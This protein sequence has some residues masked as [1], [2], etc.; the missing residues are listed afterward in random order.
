MDRIGLIEAILRR[1][2]LLVLLGAVGA[3][4]S[5]TSYTS[6]PK[7]YQSTV[8][9]QLNPA[10]RSGFLPYGPGPDDSS[11]YTNTLTSLAA[12]YREVLRSG[13]FANVVVQ[14]LQLPVSPDAVANAVSAALV[15]NT[16]VMR[17]TVTWDNPADAQQLAKAVTDVFITESLPQ[18]QAQVGIQQHLTELEDSNK[19]MKQILPELRLQRDR[20]DQ[21]VGRGDLS[22]LNDLNDL[23]TRLTAMESANVSVMSEITR[24]QTQLDTAT[25]LESATVGH[26]TETL[27]LAQSLLLGFAG[28]LALAATLAVILE[29]LRDVVRAPEDVV[30]LTG[31]APIAA[32]GRVGGGGSWRKRR[33]TS[34]LVFL[35]TPRS[36]VAESFRILRSN[37][38][39]ATVHAPVRTVLVTS[40]GP[41]EGKSL[42]SCNLAL[43]LAQSG[44]RVLL[45]DADMRRPSIH[46][47]FGLD[48]HTGLV[49]L[50]QAAQRGLLDIDASGTVPGVVSGGVAN[51]SVL[52]A[53]RP[54][55]N[56]SEL[57]GYP[58]SAGVMEQLGR[59]FDIV[60]IDSAPV[61]PVT[62]GQLL[63]A[64]ADGVLVVV[65]SGQ[66]HRTALRGAL[67]ALKYAGRPVL[68]TV[69]NDLRPGV[70]SRYT[71]YGYYYSGYYG[72]QYTDGGPTAVQPAPLSLSAGP[73]IPLAVRERAS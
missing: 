12:S 70:L 39:F 57:I 42:T 4:L 13:G 29:R 63:A 61:G 56:P 21:A 73:A 40:A 62:D 51:L 17:L 34:D 24:T 32:I 8:S 60:L 11:Y 59:L 26:S 10:A 64:F 69:L 7:R 53:G 44:Q 65:R 31:E 28:G 2:W 30:A 3:G 35:H 41:S 6:T 38:M 33:K 68:G 71:S 50:L 19:S 49:D 14:R 54:P 27:P 55:Y 72:K 20:L 1:W 15:P 16:N 48:N 45:V 18:H 37:L 66:T 67:E 58:T 23:N 9:L 43:A 47:A 5:Y 22:R 46:T 36:P 25:V 52:P